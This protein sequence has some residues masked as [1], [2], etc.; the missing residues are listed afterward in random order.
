MFIQI[1]YTFVSVYES[2]HPFYRGRQELLCSKRLWE[3]REEISNCTVKALE[4]VDYCGQVTQ[5]LRYI[6]EE[7]ALAWYAQVALP[8][9][10]LGSGVCQRVSSV[11]G[12]G[13]QGWLCL[14][15]DDRF[16]GCIHT[17]LVQSKDTK[18]R[19]KGF[20]GMGQRRTVFFIE[21]FLTF[22][23]YLGNRWQIASLHIGS[24]KSVFSSRETSQDTWLVIVDQS[25]SLKMVPS[26]Q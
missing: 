9:I 1:A 23:I 2:T 21:I 16:D 26:R 25:Q 12:L 15:I 6:I 7:P 3:S 10:S 22:Q 14:P 8:C 13:R 20:S 5:A 17:Y 18:E 4:N 24:V 19:G 11:E